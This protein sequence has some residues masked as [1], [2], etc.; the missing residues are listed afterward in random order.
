MLVVLPTIVPRTPEKVPRD[1]L[2]VPR[3]PW[4]FLEDTHHL[5]A[6]YVVA[7]CYCEEWMV[8]L[9]PHHQ[10]I[11]LF[12]VRRKVPRDPSGVPREPTGVRAN[13]RLLEAWYAA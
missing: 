5:E 10:T 6:I 8:I 1:P 3:E 13:L 11:E 9:C 7:T 2:G 4:T 12:D